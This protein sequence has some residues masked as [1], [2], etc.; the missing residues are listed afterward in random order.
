MSK[1]Y[2]ALKHAERQKTVLS[3]PREPAD[4]P[5]VIVKPEQRPMPTTDM[6]LDVKVDGM[7]T[8]MISLYHTIEASLPKTPKRVVL[9][10][11][12]V[13]GEGTSTIAQRLATVVSFSL[14]KSVLLVDLDRSRPVSRVFPDLRA[15][16]GLEDVVSGIV[17]IDR[18]ICRVEESGL[19]VT[20]LDKA[21]KDYLRTLEF[22]KATDFLRRLR[23]QFDL[24]IIDAPP[25]SVFPDGLS[26]AGSVDG[27]VLIVEAEKTK[28]SVVKDAKERLI[29]GGANVLGIVFNKSKSYIPE[30]LEKRF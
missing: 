6:S 19:H 15:E 13:S 22:A 30:W 27:V 7:E 8:E 21:S 12:S 2:E 17:P 3:G 14:G 20:G 1:V 16:N 18:A 5:D 23:D 25:L 9:C 26:I 11:G 10:I 29:K 24:V 28:W 4:A